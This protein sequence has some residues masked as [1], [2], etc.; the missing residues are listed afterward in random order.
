M[1]AEVC[2][3]LPTRRRIT[4]GFSERGRGVHMTVPSFG[5]AVVVREADAEVLGMAPVTV[6]LLADS[7][8]TGGALSVMRPRLAEGANGALPHTHTRSAELFYVL[9][10]T[11][12]ILTGDQVVTANEGDVA[13]VPPNMAHAFAAAPG[14]AAELLIVLTP[15][16]ERFGYFRL[17]ERLAKGEATVED[18]M[19][20][21]DLYDNHFLESAAWQEVR[22]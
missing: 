1:L 15:G 8:A 17:L 3:D 5:D 20:S 14:H 21:Q 18:L 22:G 12:Q 4:L 11:V 13:V 6:R 9:G 2:E 16:I 7:D 19:A 10:G